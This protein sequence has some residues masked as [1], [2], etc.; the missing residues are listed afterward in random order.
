MKGGGGAGGDVGLAATLTLGGIA[1]SVAEA[2]VQP[3][4]VIRTRMMVQGA[5]SSAKAYTSFFDAFKS[6]QSTEGISGFYKGGQIN[7]MFTP[8]ARGLF[9]AGVDGTKSYL[10]DDSAAKNFVAGMN[11]QLL[12]SVAYVPRDIIVERCAIEGQVKSTTGS[13]AS[14]LAALRTVFATEGWYGFYRAFLPHQM[15]WIPFNG[16][17][18]TFLHF[19]Q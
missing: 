16:L 6:I 5:D 17:F 15:V 12:A 2:C 1:G 4:L 7:M 14:S 19:T 8:I 10:G 3:A 9:M 18:F 13:A 11:G